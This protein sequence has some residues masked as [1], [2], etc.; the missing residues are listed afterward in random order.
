MKING[1]IY[2]KGFCK[3]L[4]KTEGFKVISTQQ[5]ENAV[6]DCRFWIEKTSPRG[7]K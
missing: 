6:I 5:S 7:G 2:V 4:C 3:V 1:V